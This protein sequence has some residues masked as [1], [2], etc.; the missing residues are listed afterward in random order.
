MTAS[1]L[2]KPLS[3]PVPKHASLQDG[4]GYVPIVWLQEGRPV[5][6]RRPGALFS[7]PEASLNL[8]LRLVPTLWRHDPPHPRP[9]PLCGACSE[10]WLPWKQC[11]FMPC[12]FPT[13]SPLGLGQNFYSPQHMCLSLNQ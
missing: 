9:A 10:P 1:P 7:V 2:Q 5:D 3:K 11:Q 12:A 8:P 13:A 4:E 6:S